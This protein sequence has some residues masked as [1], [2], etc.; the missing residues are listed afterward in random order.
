MAKYI[1]C[2]VIPVAL[3]TNTSTDTT[4]ALKDVGA[5][6]TVS[7]AIKDDTDATFKDYD[8][9]QVMPAPASTETLQAI[10]D[11]VKATLVAAGKL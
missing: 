10:F 7:C 5:P 4:A 2:V 8:V 6:Y 3:G 11:R 9:R 1:D